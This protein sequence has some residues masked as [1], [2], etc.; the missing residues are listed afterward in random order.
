MANGDKFDVTKLPGLEETDRGLAFLECATRNDIDAKKEF[1][2]LNS[3][4]QQ[5]VLNRRPLDS[6]EPFRQVLSWF[7][8]SSTV[9]AP[10]DF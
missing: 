4:L 3:K 7:S 2:K 9:S 10:L 8:I 5:D 6:R 1:D